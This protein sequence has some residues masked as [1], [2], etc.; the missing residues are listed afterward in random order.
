MD[1]MGKI[2][3]AKI[4]IVDD[5]TISLKLIRRYLSNYGYKHIVCARSAK[6]AFE[7]LDPANNEKSG[8]QIDLILMDIVMDNMNGIEAVRHIKKNEKL[9]NIPVVMITGIRESKTLAEAFSAGAVDYITKPFDK[10]ELKARVSSVLMLE[11]EI[12]EHKNAEEKLKTYA[13]KLAHSNRELQDF[14]NV[15]SHDLQEPLRKVQAFGDRLARKLEGKIGE[16]EAD[17]LKRMQSAASRMQILINDLLSLAR[18]TTKARPFVPVDLDLITK[19]TL[20]DLEARVDQTKGHVDVGKLPVID[21]DP[22]QMRQLMQNLIG[23]ALKYHKP[24][25]APV[26]KVSCV[27]VNGGLAEAVDNGSSRMAKITVE[28]NGIGFDEKYIDRVFGVFQRLHNRS[29]Y[30]G[31]GIGLPICRKIAERHGGSITAESA[32]GKGASFIAT[33]PV[34]QTSVEDAG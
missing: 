23:N 32:P 27:F 6:E 28:D 25:Q 5:S 9:K 1:I 7:I 14:A 26:V 31:T 33:L 22:T 13:E 2:E 3:N 11:H 16:K 29:E 10:T 30:E 15:A 8:A 12:K 24:D 34:K 4:M 21:A 19:E 17:Y 18:V 20:C